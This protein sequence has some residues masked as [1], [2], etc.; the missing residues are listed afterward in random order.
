[1]GRVCLLAV[2]SVSVA[3]E[4]GV[5]VAQLAYRRFDALHSVTTEEIVSAVDRELFC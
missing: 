1:M 4:R 3:G 5:V 2:I